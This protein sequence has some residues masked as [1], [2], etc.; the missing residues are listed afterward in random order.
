MFKL[1]SSELLVVYNRDAGSKEVNRRMCGGPC[2]FMPKSTEW[3]HTFIWHDQDS[4]EIGHVVPNARIF[5]DL[6]NKPDFFH[7]FVKNLN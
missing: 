7:Y 4:N 2:F 5:Q 6:T 1:N 3:L